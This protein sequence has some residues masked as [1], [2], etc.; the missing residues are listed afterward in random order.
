MSRQTT[1]FGLPLS[2]ALDGR[3]LCPDCGR[4][5]LITQSL[6]GHRGANHPGS[7]QPADLPG[8]PGGLIER[9]LIPPDAEALPLEWP[10]LPEPIEV[11]PAG[12]QPDQNDVEPDE[13]DAVQYKVLSLFLGPSPG[14]FLI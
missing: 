7:L 13:K 4:C 11:T 6:A 14:L 12:I 8:E 2:S 9:L 5:F 3:H 1:L 10:H